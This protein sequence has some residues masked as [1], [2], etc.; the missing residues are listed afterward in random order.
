MPDTKLARGRYQGRKGAIRDNTRAE[1]RGDL[2]RYWLPELGGRAVAKLNTRD[3]SA[4]IA[5]RAGDD[6]LADRTLRRLFAPVAALLATAVEE[7]YVKHNVARDVRL[8]SG[9][10]APRWF[11]ED[12]NDEDDDPAPGKARALT[13]DQLAAFV[14]VVDPRWR[15]FFE[16]LA[17]TGLHVS[18]AIPL[19]WRD[20]AL[21]GSRP[22]VRVRRARVCGAYG[23]PNVSPRA[24]RRPAAI[25]GREGAA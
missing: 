4:V 15:L 7:D 9:R 10:D 17:A 14:L 18:E 24:P 2:E 13:R 21:D 6:C 5:A 25:R 3:L 20:L 1:Y 23:P 22:I 8:P 11:D 19:R 12:A 16:L